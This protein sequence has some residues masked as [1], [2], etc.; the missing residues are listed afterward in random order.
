MKQLM[1]NIFGINITYV[2]NRVRTKQVNAI[3]GHSVEGVYTEQQWQWL[4][5]RG[6]VT[7]LWGNV[8][9]TCFLSR[10][11]I[12]IVVGPTSPVPPTPYLRFPPNFANLG[13]VHKCL[14]MALYSMATF[15]YKTTSS[16]TQ[17]ETLCNLCYNI[18][19]K[20]LFC[21]LLYHAKPNWTD[22]TGTLH[23]SS[24]YRLPRSK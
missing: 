5:N 1:G 9:H 10:T 15:L 6:S 21:Q 20:V 7:Q 13:N 2:K 22:S 3:T 4:S 23:R 8:F 17:L 18:I 12:N 14:T 24:W 16:S 11:I 19:K